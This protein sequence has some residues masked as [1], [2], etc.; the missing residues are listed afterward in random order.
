MATKPRSEEL[1]RETYEAWIAHD[2]NAGAAARSLGRAE[3]TFKSALEECKAKGMHL[4]EGAQRAVSNAGLSGIEARG[5]W[6]HNYDYEGKKIG[7]T[8]WNA[9]EVDVDTINDRIRDAFESLPPAK[10]VVRS[11]STKREDILA[12]LPHADWHLGMNVN[13]QQTGKDYNRH[14][15]VDTI[16]A[17]TERCIASQPACETAIIMNAGDLLH[18]ND[19]ADV[20][21]RNKHKLKVEGTHHQN[22]ETAVETTVGL[23]DMALS[24]HGSVEYRAIPGNHDPNI[25]GPLSVALRAY[26][27][28][29]PR[30]KIVVDEN[31]FYQRNFGVNFIAAH[32]GDGR[33]PK[34][35]AAGLPGRFPQEWG[36]AKHWHFFT[37]H[38]HHH[39]SDTFGHVR[40]FQ[41]PSV[42]SLDTHAADLNYGGS[43]GLRAITFHKANGLETD[44]TVNL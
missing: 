21:P 33:N 28:Q 3:S 32:H 42:C 35:L 14:V 38:C 36:K 22:F 10:P 31:K 30:V 12:F 7:T 9:P 17:G 39:K 44:F 18:A 19:D 41:L 11:R 1:L 29:E 15:A 20:T 37:A 2:K 34:E 8:R 26:Y 4:S 23:I 6:I 13:E 43:A 25:P 40:W 27:R 5:G 16:L 24:W